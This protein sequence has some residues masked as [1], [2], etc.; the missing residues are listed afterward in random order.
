VAFVTANSV[1]PPALLL[2]PEISRCADFETLLHTLS[3]T[4][5]LELMTLP[6]N[7]SCNRLR[8]LAQKTFA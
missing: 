4:S 8:L 7:L 2:T 1:P 6:N 3:S 5:I